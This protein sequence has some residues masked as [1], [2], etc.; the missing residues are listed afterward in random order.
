MTAHSKGGKEQYP[1]QE[2]KANPH[3][4]VAKVRHGKRLQNLKNSN[5]PKMNQKLPSSLSLEPYFRKARS[6]HSAL[7]D[8]L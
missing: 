8:T 2:R 7:R 6:L 1:S 4:T 5:S 3:S